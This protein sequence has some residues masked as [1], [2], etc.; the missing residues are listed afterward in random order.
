MN[1]NESYHGWDEDEGKH[2]AF[3]F[4]NV[5]GHRKGENTFVIDAF[6][7]PS[8]TGEAV[9]A[10]VAAI[11]Q[12]KCKLHLVKNASTTA[13]ISKLTDA[14]MLKTAP[15]RGA[16]GQEELGVLKIDTTPKRK[17]AWWKFW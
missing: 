7:D 4:S 6:G 13:V 3:H 2:N 17:R 15:V 12:F 5:H 8:N 11:K 10:M 14:A 1:Q 16:S 9:S